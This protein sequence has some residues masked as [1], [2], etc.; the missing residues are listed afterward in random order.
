MIKSGYPPN[1]Q[2]IEMVL[3]VSEKNVFSYYPDIYVPSGK[4]LEPDLMLHENIH[5]EQQKA[6]GT[7]KWWRQ[8]LTDKSFRLEQEL[9]AFA[10][11]LAYG[12]KVY[13]VKVSDQMKHDFACLLSG[14]Q[15]Q[16]GLTY[17]EAENQLRR[18]AIDFEKTML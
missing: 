5:L 17:Q 10:A 18:K 14:E 13:P 2:E 16:T 8:F 12:K 15:Y 11:Q 7:E 6:I 4:E 1:I 9:A 3:P